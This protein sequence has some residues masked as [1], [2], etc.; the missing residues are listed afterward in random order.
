MKR[1]GTRVFGQCH[2]NSERLRRQEEKPA[3]ITALFMAVNI[4]QGCG[5]VIS[6]VISVIQRTSYCSRSEEYGF[7]HEPILIVPTESNRPCSSCYGLEHRL[8]GNHTQ[9]NQI[10]DKALF[11]T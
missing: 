2:K 4:E 10:C 8:L 7:Q 1:R 11:C 3:E 9:G 6:A 5:R